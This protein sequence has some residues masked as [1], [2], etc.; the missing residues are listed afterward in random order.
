MHDAA[1]TWFNDNEGVED[2]EDDV[3]IKGVHAGCCSAAAA[4]CMEI[5]NLC[6][7]T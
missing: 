5:S 6:T 3:V 7:S 2:C 1:F 4:V